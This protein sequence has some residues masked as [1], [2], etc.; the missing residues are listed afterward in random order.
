MLGRNL[1][2]Q[3]E[4]QH[5]EIVYLLLHLIS[6]PQFEFIY[7][8]L[9]WLPYLVIQLVAS[10]RHLIVVSIQVLSLYKILSLSG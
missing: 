4:G 1:I 10:T 8:V 7:L 5:F 2:Q 6:T 9:F 3:L